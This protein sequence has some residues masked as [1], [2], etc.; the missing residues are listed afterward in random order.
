MKA[1]LFTFV[2]TLSCVRAADDAARIGRLIFS[3]T[4]LSHPVGQGC[5]SCHSPKHAFADPR[6]VSAGAVNGREGTRNAP[7]LM[8][9]ALLLVFLDTLTDRHLLE[10]N[11]SIFPEPPVGVPTTESLKLYFPDWTHRLHPAFPSE[12]NLHRE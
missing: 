3:D 1:C 7:S 4:S 11:D 8:Y 10:K 6:P 9:A 2:L 5:I 12:Q